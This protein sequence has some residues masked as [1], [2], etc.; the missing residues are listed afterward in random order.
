MSQ[1]RAG[2]S[3]AWTTN[4]LRHLD[5]D[6]GRPS[7]DFPPAHH[8]DGYPSK[9]IRHSSHRATRSCW[10]EPRLGALEDSEAD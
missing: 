9:V 10:P 7:G 5:Y 4:L 6:I 2:P 1:L 8:W 3:R